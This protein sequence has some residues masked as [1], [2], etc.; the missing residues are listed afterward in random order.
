MDWLTTSDRMARGVEN[1]IRTEFAKVQGAAEPDEL[2]PLRLN[3][4]QLLYSFLNFVRRAYALLVHFVR[5]LLVRTS[6]N[7]ESVECPWMP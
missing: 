4:R 1:L 5:S 6:Y 2:R 7:W 3:W